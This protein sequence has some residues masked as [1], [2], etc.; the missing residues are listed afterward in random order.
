MFLIVTLILYQA[1][2]T[3]TTKQTAVA[4]GSSEAIL[5]RNKS[6]GGQGPLKPA[7]AEELFAKLKRIEHDSGMIDD[8]IAELRKTIEED[9]RKKLEHEKVKRGERPPPQFGDP[10]FHATKAR[11]T[12]YDPDSAINSL[13]ISI[14]RSNKMI[15]ELNHEKEGLKREAKLTE[16]QLDRYRGG[17]YVIFGTIP[18]GGQIGQVEN[19]RKVTVEPADFNATFGRVGQKPDAIPSSIDDAV[20]RAIFPLLVDVYEID[21]QERP[22]LVKEF[23]KFRLLVEHRTGVIF[24]VA[25]A[26]SAA[27]TEAVVLAPEMAK[28]AREILTVLQANYPSF[29]LEKD[30]VRDTADQ[31][32][33][34]RVTNERTD[35]GGRRIEAGKA[36]LRDLKKGETPPTNSV[37]LTYTLKS[38]EKR[39]IDSLLRIE[40]RH[41]VGGIEELK[42]KGNGL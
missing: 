25:A 16:S 34:V 31:F 20:L 2:E 42:K 7:S 15:G 1:T 24:A 14:F 17:P 21:I 12:A 9:Q 5:S 41:A 30:R 33:S 27:G 35:A 3:A 10:L 8:K 19:V 22:D 11:V 32:L 28:R 36:D 18:L 38:I 23:R 37:F 39:V 40:T 13:I 26:W 29:T 6:A 4:T